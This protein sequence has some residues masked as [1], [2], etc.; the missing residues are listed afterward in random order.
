MTDASNNPTQGFNVNV[1]YAADLRALGAVL[2]LLGEAP[3][4]AGSSN[5]EIYGPIQQVYICG[6]SATHTLILAPGYSASSYRGLI[7]IQ[8]LS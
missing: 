8:R 1:V 7:D 3:Q 6:L 4:R 5:Y 2:N